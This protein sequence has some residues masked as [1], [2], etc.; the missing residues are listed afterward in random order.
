[1]DLMT[2]LNGKKTYIIAGVMVVLGVLQGLDVFTVPNEVWATLGG[3]AFITM[4]KGIGKVA[5]EVERSV[6]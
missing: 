6:R 5:K 2:W 4:R 3:G 1:M